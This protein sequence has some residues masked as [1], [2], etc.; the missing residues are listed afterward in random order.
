AYNSD[1]AFVD[2]YAI[3]GNY[4][5]FS[6]WDVRNKDVPPALVG[7]AA[8]LGAQ[9]DVSAYGNIVNTSTDSRRASAACDA[10]AT[11]DLDDYW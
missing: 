2:G 8:C 10:P 9:N 1:L 3:Q 11:S 5:G 6:I 7:Q 4:N